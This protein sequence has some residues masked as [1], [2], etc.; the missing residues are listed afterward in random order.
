MEAVMNRLGASYKFNDVATLHSQFVAFYY[1]EEA[2]PFSLR[3]TSDKPQKYELALGFLLEANLGEHWGIFLELAGLGLNYAN[4]Y[5]HG[6]YSFFYRFS[7]GYFQL[8]L[9]DS[10][11]VRTVEYVGPTY[12]SGRFVQQESV[13]HPEV[14]LQF[15]F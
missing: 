5:M 10:T 4:V 12:S 6:G 13:Y 14:A 2:V 15:T 3:L 7:S 11:T 8:G 9:S 1:F